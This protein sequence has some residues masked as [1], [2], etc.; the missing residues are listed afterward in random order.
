MHIMEG[1]LPMGWSIAWWVIV[2]PFLYYGTRNINQM[3]KERPNIKM[4]LAMVGAFAFVL[5][6][7]KLPSV[8]GSCSHPTGVGMGTILFGAST[9][10]VLGFIVLV[11]QALLLAHGG[12]TTLGANTFSMGVC[13]PISTWLVYRLSLK[14]GLTQR[15]AIF[16][17]VTL[18]D[19]VTYLITS[20]Q[21]ALAHPDAQSGFLGSMA[22]FS[23][24]FAFTQLPLAISEGLLTVFVLNVIS[25][26]AW[27]E[28][29]LFAALR[30]KNNKN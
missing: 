10:S 23:G 13:G 11:F 9:M 16:L 4:L 28:L 20:T 6:A 1:F 24:I 5:S 27:E 2:I 7:L 19:L 18:G 29:P 22:K 3:V 8:T 25:Q 26:Y 15:M 21:L 17:A 14:W 12:I 30:G